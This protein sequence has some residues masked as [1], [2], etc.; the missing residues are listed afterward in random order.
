MKKTTLSLAILLIASVGCGPRVYTSNNL[1]SAI[2]EDKSVA[3]LPASVN[4]SLRPN[5][6]KKMTVEQ[7]RDNE[8]TTAYAIQDKMYGWFLRNDPKF[9]YTVAF[10][11]VNKT[12]ALLDSAHIAYTDL[13]TKDKVAL[14]KLLGVD[15]VISTSLRMEKPMSEGAAVAIYALAGAWGTT[16][17]ASV[18]IDAR[19]VHRGEL[20]WKYEY[21]A[22]G[23]MFSSAEDLVNML[24]RNASKKF[25][26][27]GK[28]N[29]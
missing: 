8:K 29:S 7:L 22:G 13:A 28:D 27:N 21:E 3:I 18:N 26:Y 24:M 9:H 5:Q 12:N 6:A 23:S 10:L 2:Q 17:K 4:I 20:V 14:A 1:Q 16:N 19:E 11:D 15:V 25:P